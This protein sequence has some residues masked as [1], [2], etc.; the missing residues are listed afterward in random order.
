MVN[1]LEVECAR[2]ESTANKVVDVKVTHTRQAGDNGEAALNLFG[3]R[4]QGAAYS[5]GV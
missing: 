5:I 1:V 4:K 3:R 2:G